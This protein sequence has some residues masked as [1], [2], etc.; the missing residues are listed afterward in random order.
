MVR[1]NKIP[2]YIWCLSHSWPIRILKAKIFK[3]E[4]FFPVAADQ[5]LVDLA[6]SY[7]EKYCIKYGEENVGGAS[8]PQPSKGGVS[9]HILNQNPK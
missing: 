3:Q 5:Q 6:M 1:S 4:D 8:I 7:F 9:Q 2:F